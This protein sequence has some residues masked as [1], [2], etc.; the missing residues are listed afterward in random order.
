MR[1]FDSC[2]SCFMKKLLINSLKQKSPIAL[3]FKKTLNNNK[4]VSQFNTNRKNYRPTFFKKSSFLLKSSY[5]QDI[6]NYTP[7]TTSSSLHNYPQLL[8]LRTGLRVKTPTSTLMPEFYTNVLPPKV[9]LLSSSSLL[10]RKNLTSLNFTLPSVNLLDSLIDYYLSNYVLARRHIHS[11]KAAIIIAQI[12]DSGHFSRR[13]VYLSNTQS[14]SLKYKAKLTNY[15][16]SYKS[17]LSTI[18]PL[19][20][21]TRNTTPLDFN[22]YPTKQELNIEK[23]KTNQAL[24]NFSSLEA[25]LNNLLNLAWSYSKQSSTRNHFKFLKKYFTVRNRRFKKTNFINQYRNIFF[26]MK[27]HVRLNTQSRL[28]FV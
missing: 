15:F 20:M 11:K 28:N 23:I 10:S 3:K 21:L 19:L 5:N 1:G 4:R 18:N 17:P 8:Y 16:S 2:Y 14:V 6:Y 25:L 13:T 27:K 7:Y 9:N 26:L 22:F 24:A 12:I